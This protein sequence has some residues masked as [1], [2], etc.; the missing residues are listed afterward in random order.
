VTEGLGVDET[1][2]FANMQGV[3]G[4][5]GAVREEGNKED[6]VGDNS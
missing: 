4:D 2:V 6:W 3:V 5:K 1:S